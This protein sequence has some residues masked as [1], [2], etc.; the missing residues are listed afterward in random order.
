MRRTSWALILTAALLLTITMA[1]GD[2]DTLANQSG[3]GINDRLGNLNGLCRLNGGSPGGYSTDTV[4]TRFYCQGGALDGL[5]CD[6]YT[7][8]T[9]FYWDRVG[10]GSAPAGRQDVVNTSV[11]QDLTFVSELPAAG[12]S[13]MPDVVS[14]PM[15][16]EAVI[17]W[18]P[19]A[20]TVNA[21]G[22]VQVNACRMLGGEE[23]VARPD[24]NPE[25]T[26]FTVGCQDGLL[27]GMW[28]A[29]GIGPSACFF[30]PTSQET[31][32]AETPAP[33]PTD[34]P[35]APNATPSPTEVPTPP[36]TVAPTD[37]PVIEPTFVDPTVSD[38]P[39]SLPDG[40]LSPIDPAP[41]PTE[42]P[43]T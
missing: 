19:L 43:L 1:I 4:K 5:Y 40:T 13:S 25:S 39:W 24:G 32:T 33:M 21:A 14:Q 30:V 8:L 36:E 20:E 41:S 11:N 6:V 23:A 17:T 27:D 26:T 3:P 10:K 2:K 34:M 35:Q 9:Y 38:D 15:L 7:D 31:T 18:N 12:I 16:V 42:A 28:C 22:I 29:M 37:E